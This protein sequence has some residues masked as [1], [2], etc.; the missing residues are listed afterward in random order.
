MTIPIFFNEDG[1]T[2]IAEVKAI[3]EA[4]MQR[5][6]QPADPEMLLINAFS[7]RE[8]LRNKAANLTVLQ[9]LVYWANSVMLD[10][11]C[12]QLGVFRIPAIGAKC[13]FQITLAAG[14]TGVVLP[15]GIRIQSTDLQVIFITDE[16]VIVAAG[17]L[18]KTVIGTAQTTGSIGNNYAPGNISVVMDP[19]PFVMAIANTDLTSGGADDETDDQLRARYPLALS[20][21]SVASPKQAYIYWA[22]TAHQSIID[23]AVTNP[24]PGH[25]NIYPLCIGGTLPTTEILAAVE[26]ICSADKVRPLCDI[27]TVAA[28]TSHDYTISVDLTLYAN[29]D[30]SATT[31]LVNTALSNLVKAGKNK[32]GKDIVLS[33]ISAACLVPGVYNVSVVTPASDYVANDNVYTNCTG[34]TINITGTAN[35]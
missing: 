25:V 28:P 21:F 1:A 8:L 19:Q 30:Q 33:Q 3:A 6:I 15:L 24:T 5:V 22:K 16:Q 29:A 12:G 26:A 27:V 18:T 35:G 13:T 23:V 10:E 32:L 14:N 17:E 20:S 7:Y 11:L 9:N 2:I 31:V 34:I 4:E